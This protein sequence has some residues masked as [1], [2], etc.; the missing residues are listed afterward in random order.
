APR[1]AVRG[2]PPVLASVMPDFVRYNRQSPNR[3]GLQFA[4]A[5][6]SY[7]DSDGP[8]LLGVFVPWLLDI[9]PMVGWIQLFFDISLFCSAT[10]LWHRFQLW[11]IHTNRVRP[12]D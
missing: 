6:R 11:R 3:T 8:D 10:S 2:L 12:Q 9:M 7:F 5:A 1:S 4:P